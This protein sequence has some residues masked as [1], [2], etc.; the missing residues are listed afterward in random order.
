[1]K[2]SYLSDPWPEADRLR[3]LL[4]MAGEIAALADI[5]QH[6]CRAFSPTEIDHAR[7]RESEI[8]RCREWFEQTGN[9]LWAWAA[10]RHALNNE[11]PLPGWVRSY[12]L[13]TGESLFALVP[14][15][16]K[17]GVQ[18][19]IATAVGFP[20]PSPGAGSPFRDFERM[21]RRQHAVGR[22]VRL[23]LLSNPPMPPTKAAESIT[24]E[25]GMPAKLD[26][27]LRYVQET[28]RLSSPPADWRDFLINAL[29][30]DRDLIFSI[31]QD[32]GDPD[33]RS[34]VIPGLSGTT[35]P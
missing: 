22:F 6:R 15:P 3:H 9:P 23:V 18:E 33:L 2:A 32:S 8:E 5:W 21:L 35:V 4:Q 24:R 11:A 17:E 7:A 20:P 31:L 26:T 19:A 29:L 25:P 34:P 10:L 14:K 13:D 27:V 12:L 1:M 30:L 28:F 16:P